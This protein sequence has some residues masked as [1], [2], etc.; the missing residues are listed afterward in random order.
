MVCK[1]KA[2]ANG[3]VLDCLLLVTWGKVSEKWGKSLEF[4]V[5]DELQP[6]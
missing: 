3:N 1:K 4:L 2:K 6:C 5:S